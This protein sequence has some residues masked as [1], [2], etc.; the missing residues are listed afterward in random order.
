MSIDDDILKLKRE[1]E[2]VQIRKIET[3]TKLQA[4]ET[5]KAQLLAECQALG[6]DP[7]GIEAAIQEQEAALAK[8]VKDIQA[9]L[10]QF[11]AVRY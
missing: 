1:L 11:N 3:N 8:E 4:L 6:V 10:D 2:S 5:E 7:K 9:Q